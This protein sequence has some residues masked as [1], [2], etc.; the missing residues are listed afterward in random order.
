VVDGNDVVAVWKAARE[1]VAHARSGKGPS[2][3]EAHTYRLQGHL[4]GEALF[5]A[6]GKY[7]EQ[8]EIDVWRNRDPLKRVRKRLLA[9]GTSEKQL[10]MIASRVAI[11]VEQAV[12]FAKDSEPAD[13][14]LPFDLMFVDQKA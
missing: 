5:L 1:A 3:I 13:N 4:E 14:D 7:R 10:E 11:T 6:G 12:Q 2:Y 8:Q 9:S